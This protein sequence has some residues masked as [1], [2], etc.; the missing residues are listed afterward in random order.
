MFVGFVPV[1]EAWGVCRRARLEGGRV[2]SVESV[3]SI[4]RCLACVELE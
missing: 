4:E 3:K 1:G 2:P